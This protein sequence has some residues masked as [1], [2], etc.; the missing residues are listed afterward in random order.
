VRTL[1]PVVASRVRLDE[2]EAFLRNSAAA[3]ARLQN[4]GHTR[5]K[6]LALVL[7]PVLGVLLSTVHYRRC[8]QSPNLGT[9]SG[10]M[11]K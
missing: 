5:W 7:V 1:E 8:N 4:A 9:A 3:P 10:K 6:T 11:L 2:L